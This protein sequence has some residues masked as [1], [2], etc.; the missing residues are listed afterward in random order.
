MLADYVQ[1]G[2]SAP[3]KGHAALHPRTIC[4]LYSGDVQSVAYQSGR[5]S[6][7]D[8]SLTRTVARYDAIASNDPE[9]TAKILWREV[10]LHADMASKSVVEAPRNAIAHK[11]C[12]AHS[13][14]FYDKQEPYV[15]PM[16]VY[17]VC[18][19]SAVFDPYLSFYSG[20]DNCLLPGVGKDILNFVHVCM[21]AKKAQ[22][23]LEVVILR[24]VHSSGYAR[25]ETL[26][27]SGANP[28]SPRMSMSVSELPAVL[29]FIPAKVRE[30]NNTASAAT[31]ERLPIKSLRC[32]S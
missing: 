15:S 10:S 16:R 29:P 28:K 5:F 1:I 20:I 23:A 17:F 18:V 26:L 30:I 27:S 32:Q 9:P 3:C 13:E 12:F 31:G 8:L 7:A 6:L 19:G 14:H 11:K 24:L 21:Q 4:S 22:E 25:S 2:H